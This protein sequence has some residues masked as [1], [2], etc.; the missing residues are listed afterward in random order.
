M[1]TTLGA[2]LLGAF[3]ATGSSL[4]IESRRDRRAIAAEWRKERRELYGA[5]LTALLGVRS[6]LWTISRDEQMA[7]TERMSAARAIFVQCYGLRYQLEI[8][9][10]RSV[11]EPALEYFW[12]VRR[13][14]E[15]VGS[16]LRWEDSERQVHDEAVAHTLQATKVA[17]RLDMKTDA[18]GTDG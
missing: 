6:D 11:V 17:M 14:R 7:D 2:T 10:P 1:W 12:S 5:F 4:L 16:G 18:T 3:I 13:L 15:A 9:A 8:F